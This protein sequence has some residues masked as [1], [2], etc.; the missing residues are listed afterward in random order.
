M[1]TQISWCDSAIIARCEQVLSL[2]GIHP[3]RYAALLSAN[4][5]ATDK[6]AAERKHFGI[7]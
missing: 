6:R 3:I 1:F 4:N 5:A 2:C 7:G